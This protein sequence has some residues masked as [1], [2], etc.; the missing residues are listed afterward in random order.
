M[1]HDGKR[2]TL[3]FYYRGTLCQLDTDYGV[4]PYHNYG[5]YHCVAIYFDTLLEAR[6]VLKK[7]LGDACLLP[8]E[9]YPYLKDCEKGVLIFEANK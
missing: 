6:K 4:E 9:G 3:G 7:I 1:I 2:Y 8:V 5:H